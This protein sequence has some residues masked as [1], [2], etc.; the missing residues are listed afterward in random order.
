[1][2]LL[3]RTFGVAEPLRRG[4]ELK[5]VRDAD[6]FRPTVLG[7]PSRLHEDILTGR[8][9]EVSW[10]DI[11]DGQDGVKLGLDAGGDGSAVGWTEEI[12]RK[13]GM[14]KW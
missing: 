13:V 9:D 4:M 5:M 8:D 1:M 2:T 14:W 3:R 10:E 7:A 6:A 12:E 11:Y